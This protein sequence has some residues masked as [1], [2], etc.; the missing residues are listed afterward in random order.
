MVTLGNFQSYNSDSQKGAALIVSLVILLAIT[1]LG[2]ASLRSGIFH[3]RMSLNSQAEALTFLGAESSI[4]GILSFAL[5]IRE[6]RVD[7]SFFADAVLGT[8]QQ[9]CVTRS[10][11]ARAFCVDI[12][13]AL[14]TRDSGVVFAQAE[15][16]YKHQTKIFNSDPDTLAY[17]TFTTDGTSY[18]RGDLD[19]PFA[20]RNQQEW[21]MLGVAM[22][23]TV[24]ATHVREARAAGN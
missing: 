24:S 2:V 20:T 6:D 21:K 3:E 19:L 16:R 5:E 14:D 7:D 11:I 18:L 12:S 23:F 9:N 8:G 4:N 22:P 13:Q 15:T 17:H 10:G 1:L